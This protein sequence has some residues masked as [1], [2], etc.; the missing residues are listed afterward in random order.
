GQTFRSLF[1]GLLVDLAVRDNDAVIHR[2]SYHITVQGRVR[3][4]T[5]LT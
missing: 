2:I 5:G 1:D 3:F 4:V